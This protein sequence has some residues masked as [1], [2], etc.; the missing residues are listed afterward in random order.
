M[1]DAFPIL[2]ENCLPKEKYIKMTRARMGEACKLCDRPFDVYKWRMEESN[3]INKTYVCLNCARIKNMCQCCLKDI[4]YNIP[5]YV[6]D[7]A[8]AQV[9][10]SISQTTSL[11]EA[12]KEWLI[13]V[14]QKKYEITGQSEYDKVDPNKVIEKLE[15]KFSYV[16]NIPDIAKKTQPLIEKHELKEQSQLKKAYIAKKPKKPQSFLK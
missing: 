7:A 14:S 5:Y 3:S 15:K 16:S 2:C 12:N 13:E 4:E 11:N 10:G 8:L 9:N 1:S 6:R